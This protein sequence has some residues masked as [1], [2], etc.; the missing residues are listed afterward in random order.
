MEKHDFG[1]TSWA[2][3]EQISK[4]QEKKKSALYGT[5]SGQEDFFLD[6]TLCHPPGR[7]RKA[8]D[9]SDMPIEIHGIQENHPKKSLTLLGKTNIIPN[10]KA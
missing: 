7:C 6:E 10:D 4:P 2:M 3:I 9:M 5:F 8:P 1:L